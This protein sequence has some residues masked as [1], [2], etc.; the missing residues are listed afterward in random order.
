MTL[1]ILTNLDW[2]EMS[3]SQMM[4]AGTYAVFVKISSPN[5]NDYIAE[6][7]ESFVI[8]KALLQVEVQDFE[9]VYGDDIDANDYQH[10]FTGFKGSD[11]ESALNIPQDKNKYFIL[12]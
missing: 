2:K 4:D 10:V 12:Y 1:K 5:Y 7:T 3:V 9:V 11:D 6:K 8:K